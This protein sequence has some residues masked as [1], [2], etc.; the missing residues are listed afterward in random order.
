MIRQNLN[1]PFYPNRRD[2]RKQLKKSSGKMNKVMENFKILRKYWPPQNADEAPE[3]SADLKCGF[4]QKIP[5]RLDKIY[6]CIQCSKCGCRDCGPRYLIQFGNFV[7]KC[8]SN[9]CFCLEIVNEIAKE[10]N[11]N[12]ESGNY[13]YN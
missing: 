9:N 2:D 13:C 8:Q 5:K 1:C 7:W 12:V 6:S 3:E 11:K 10:K 4:C